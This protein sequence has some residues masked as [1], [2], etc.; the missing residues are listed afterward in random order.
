[1]RTGGGAATITMLN[2]CAALEG[3]LDG[4]WFERAVA[5]A[6]SG[7][8]VV[9]LCAATNAAERKGLLAA[10]F[11]AHA[12]EACMI[13]PLSARARAAITRPPRQW[14][15]VTESIVGV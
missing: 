6:P 5:H 4:E 9:S 14:Y 12:D 1:V 2:D 15:I 13:L 7:P 11:D 3:E 10:G 8:P